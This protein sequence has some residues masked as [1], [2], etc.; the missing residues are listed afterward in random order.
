MRKVLIA[1]CILVGLYFVA[2][3]IRGHFLRAEAAQYTTAALFA[4]LKPWNATS[5]LERASESLKASPQEPLVQRIEVASQQF[6][7]FSRISEGPTC[8]L[9]LGINSFDKKE[10]TYSKCTATVVFEKRSSQVTV[11]LIK[12]SGDWYINDLMFQSCQSPKC[13]LTCQCT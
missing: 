6:G 8:A 12:V 9:F 5:Y 2:I 7:D 4:I 3:P 1:I 11:I 10:R 13:T